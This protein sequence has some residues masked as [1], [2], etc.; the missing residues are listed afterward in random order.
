MYVVCVRYSSQ[1]QKAKGVIL[2]NYE[3]I[4][5]EIPWLSEIMMNRFIEVLKFNL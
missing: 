2:P 5:I 3:I 1:K 4:D